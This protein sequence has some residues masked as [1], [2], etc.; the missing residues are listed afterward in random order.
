MS[1]K[2]EMAIFKCKR[3]KFH[4]IV[5]IKLC[6]QRVYPTPSVKYLSVKIDQHL[7]WQHHVNDLSVELNGANTLLLKIRKFVYDKT[8]GSNYF[9]TFESNLNYCLFVRVQIYNVINRLVILQKKAL[10]IMNFQPRNSYTSP[11]FRKSSVLKF[12][13]KINLK[14]ILF[15]IKS[16][17]YLLSLIIGLLFPLI[18]AN[19]ISHGLLIINSSNIYKNSIII[20]IMENCALEQRII[21]RT[22]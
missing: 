14:N 11:L 21:V 17:F 20:W 10:R 4:D 18:H 9:A 22:I 12:K 6:G 19:I 16:I 2:A 3:K 13:D 7:T 5:K 8:L 15:I 1:K